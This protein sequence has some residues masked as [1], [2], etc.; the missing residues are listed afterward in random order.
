M[1]T[2]NN[3]LDVFFKHSTAPNGHN[4]QRCAAVHYWK[5]IYT[6]Q[7][8]INEEPRYLTCAWLV[9]QGEGKCFAIY[10]HAVIVTRWRIST[11]VVSGEE[12]LRLQ[13]G[14]QKRYRQHCSPGFSTDLIMSSD[15]FVPRRTATAMM[16]NAHTSAGLQSSLKIF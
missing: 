7:S 3:L 2:R 16:Y 9:H 12:T 5:K 11:R 14:E 15:I 13:I 8:A 1:I 6:S 10:W 4:S